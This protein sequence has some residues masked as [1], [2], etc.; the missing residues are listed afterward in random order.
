[1]STGGTSSEF[2]LVG[3]RLPSWARPWPPSHRTTHPP[4]ASPELARF[5]SARVACSGSARA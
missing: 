5:R 3:L 2:T 1:L 4:S